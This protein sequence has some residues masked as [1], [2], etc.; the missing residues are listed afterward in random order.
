MKK[1]HC[2]LFFALGVVA[3]LLGHT[4]SRKLNDLK[5]LPDD[6]FDDELFE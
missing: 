4:A 6:L 3:G 2:F 5:V 1:K